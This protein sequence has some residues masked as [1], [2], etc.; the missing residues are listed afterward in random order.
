MIHSKPEL[1]KGRIRLR[2]SVSIQPGAF[3]AMAVRD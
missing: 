2:F 1:Y 3:S